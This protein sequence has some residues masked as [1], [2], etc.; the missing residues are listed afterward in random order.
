MMFFQEDKVETVQLAAQLQHSAVSGEKEEGKQDFAQS[1]QPC[2][3]MLFCFYVINYLRERDLHA[4]LER[5]ILS[6]VSWF[7]LDIL[8]NKERYRATHRFFS[9]IH[10]WNT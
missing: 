9:S 4:L 2:E 3:L 10:I 7:K 5:T 6:T 8:A 1:E